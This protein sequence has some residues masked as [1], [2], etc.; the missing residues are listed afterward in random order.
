MHFFETV[1]EIFAEENIDCIGIVPLSSC[2]ILRPYLLEREGIDASG[3]GSVIAFAQP[4]YATGE[5]E[6]NISLYAV[7]RDYHAFFADLFDRVLPRLK[8][9]FPGN[10]FAAFSDHSP[11]D[12][13]HA[14]A[15]SGIGVIGKNHMLITEKYSSFVFI[16]AVICNVQTDEKAHPVMLCDDCG[17]CAV[18]CPVGLDVSRCISALSQKKGELTEEEK[19]ALIKNGSVW[20]CDICQLACPHTKKVIESGSAV[21]KTP[22]FLEKRTPYLDRK[23]IDAMSDEEFSERAYSWRGRKTIER[24]IALFEGDKKC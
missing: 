6:R 24:N 8:D 1:R 15:L 16:G 9:A 21:T 5:G 13:V 10:K 7:P 14:A 17:A 18:A 2:K 23:T 3:D 4:Y 19:E 12:E 20:G 11:I 22:F